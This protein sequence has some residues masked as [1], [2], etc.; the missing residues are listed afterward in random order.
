MQ[1]ARNV[2][3]ALDR[4]SSESFGS[5]E[6]AKNPSY[7]GKMTRPFPYLIAP[8]ASPRFFEFSAYYNLGLFKFAR[9]E[10]PFE[11]SCRG[12]F[13]PLERSFRGQFRPFPNAPPLR[14]I[15]C[16]KM[17]ANQVT[18]H[19]QPRKKNVSKPRF[20]KFAEKPERRLGGVQ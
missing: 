9:R 1:L 11:R 16:H 17:R 20:G 18:E 7:R 6:V 14:Q 10:E 19:Y 2:R 3:V 4:D 5:S 8:S 12:Q 15:S 13:Q